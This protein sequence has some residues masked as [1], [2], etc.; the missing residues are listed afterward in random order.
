MQLCLIYF[1]NLSGP[2]NFLSLPPEGIPQRLEVLEKLLDVGNEGYYEHHNHGED[3]FIVAYYI[4][5]IQSALA[6]GNTERLLIGVII[7]D[8][9]KRS[10][11]QQNLEE[12]VK[13]CKKSPE[14][15]KGLYFDNQKADRESKPQY[16]KIKEYF[17]KCY[18]ACKR[19]PNAQKPGKMIVLG[20]RSV[21]KTSVLNRLMMQDMETKPTIGMSMIRSVIDNFQF[22]FYDMSG[23]KS[24][25][26]TWFDKPVF[27]NAIIFVIDCS[28]PEQNADAREEFDRVMHH[29]FGKLSGEKLQPNTPVLVLGNKIDLNI[30]YK[31]EDIE[32]LLNPRKYKINYRIGMVSALKNIGIEENFKWLI[33]EFLFL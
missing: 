1:D 9:A 26:N 25:R 10:V 21:G 17:F 31:S 23:Q 8:Q 3:E 30:K 6:R 32:K 18:E 16:G 19:N 13:L 4:F 27:P 7:E 22:I 20:L 33:K 5:E 24:Y 12:F 15:Y 14:L 2:R 29:Y 28:V 11:Y